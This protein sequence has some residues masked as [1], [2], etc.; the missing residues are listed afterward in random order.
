MSCHYHRGLDCDC[1]CDQHPILMVTQPGSYDIIVT[2]RSDGCILD[3][4]G[5][6]LSA[7]PDLEDQIVH[8][9]E[10]HQQEHDAM[11]RKW[12]AI[13]DLLTVVQ[14]SNGRDQ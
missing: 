1:G 7:T 2:I 4:D 8:I 3:A 5:R 12:R 9:L 14:L 13:E 6:V 10:L 11:D